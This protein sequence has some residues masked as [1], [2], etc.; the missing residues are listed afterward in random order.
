M[1][2][3]YRGAVL[4]VLPKP[5]TE[6]DT[7]NAVTWKSTF[8]VSATAQRR[9]LRHGQQM[10]GFN[11]WQDWTGSLGLSVRAQKK[12]DH[13]LLSRGEFSSGFSHQAISCEVGLSEL[14]P[15]PPAKASGLLSEELRRLREQTPPRQ[16]GGR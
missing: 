11:T 12:A 3:Q 10:Q 16:P 13:W 4:H 14:P 15:L 1:Y 2:D 7:L 8:Q 6:I 9:L 5:I